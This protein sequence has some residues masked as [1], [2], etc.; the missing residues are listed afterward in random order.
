MRWKSLTAGLIFLLTIGGAACNRAPKSPDVKDQV[1]RSL[2]AAGLTDV[3]AKQDRDKGVLTLGGKVATEDDKARASEIAESQGAGQ[4]VANQI[5]VQ[6][7]GVEDQMKKTQSALDKG[8]EDN[9][10][11]EVVSNKLD[12]VDYSAKEGVLTLSG[13]VDSQARRRQVEQLAS[14]VPNV[15]QVVNTIQVAGQKAT[16][17]VR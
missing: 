16:S 6:P 1:E 7:P 9:F 8:I 13:T 14:S 3:T 5:S 15:K 17:T 11:A 12:G 4:V 10:K 2:H